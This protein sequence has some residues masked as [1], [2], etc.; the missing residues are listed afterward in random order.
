MKFFY[1]LIL[2]SFFI[3]SCGS[4]SSSVPKIKADTTPKASPKPN[5]DTLIAAVKRAEQKTSRSRMM[6]ADTANLLIKVYTDYANALPEDSARTATY[7][8]KAA[9]IARYAGELNHE[10]SGRSYYQQAL[11]LLGRIKKYP[12][13]NAIEEVYYLEALIY[14]ANLQD[15]E[16]ARN[17]YE[18][19]I[20]KF[21]DSPM[22]PGAQASIDMLGK[23]EHEKIE[24]FK[25]KNK[26]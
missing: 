1:L 11:D 18:A 14:D 24:E 3:V 13:F 26:I 4:E 19:F 7:L 16:L 5:K 8:F 20:K 6:N 10:R 15:I 22:V 21:P 25:K 2:V 12:S 23:T 9:N 17:R